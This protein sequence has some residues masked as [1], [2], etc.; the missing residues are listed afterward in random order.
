MKIA[1]TGALRHGKV[2]LK[3]QGMNIF[4]TVTEM[5]GVTALTG[6]TT[7]ES[8][9][10]LVAGLTYGGIVAIIKAIAIIVEELRKARERRK[11]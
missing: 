1:L 3:G 9:T 6:A 5:V 7:A 2:L 11:G 10:A 8:E 4:R